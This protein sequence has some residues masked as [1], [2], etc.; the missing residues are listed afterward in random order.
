MF[1]LL[2]KK[3]DNIVIVIPIDYIIGLKHNVNKR[4]STDCQFY[5]DVINSIIVYLW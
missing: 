4:N 1:S 3:S 5:Y 2:W